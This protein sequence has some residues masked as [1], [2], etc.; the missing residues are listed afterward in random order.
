M[1]CQVPMQGC[2]NGTAHLRESTR[3]MTDDLQGHGEQEILDQQISKLRKRWVDKIYKM[4]LQDL[5]AKSLAEGVPVGNALKK[6]FSK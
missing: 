2:N 3:V 4:S 1:L 6:K 5:V